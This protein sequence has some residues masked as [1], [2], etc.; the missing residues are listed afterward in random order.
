MTVG[1]ALDGSLLELGHRSKW[2]I[3]FVVFHAMDARPQ[4]LPTKKGD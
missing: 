3:R 1:P 2:G 4:F